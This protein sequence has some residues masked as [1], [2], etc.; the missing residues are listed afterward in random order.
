MN[1]LDQYLDK[2]PETKYE[3][4]FKEATIEGM[5]PGIYYPSGYKFISENRRKTNEIVKKIVLDQLNGRGIK[6]ANE[7]LELQKAKE[8]MKV[9]EIEF[10]KEGETFIIRPKK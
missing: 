7:L 9:E 6:Y 1:I 5:I 4:F 2:I 10:K 3:N 8:T